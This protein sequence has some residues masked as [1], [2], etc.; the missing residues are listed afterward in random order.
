M[1]LFPMFT[2]EG[3]P[4]GATPASYLARHIVTVRSWVYGSPP[5]AK[6]L[7]CWCCYATDMDRADELL[8]VQSVFTGSA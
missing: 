7:D 6:W 4:P 5:G 1:A 3:A 2:V 8:V